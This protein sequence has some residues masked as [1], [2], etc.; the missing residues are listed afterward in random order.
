MH[1]S[2]GFSIYDLKE[3]N[4][5]IDDRLSSIMPEVTGLKSQ[6]YLEL[7]AQMEGIN[8][9]IEAEMERLIPALSNLGTTS[10][11]FNSDIK[12]GKYIYHKFRANNSFGAKVISEVIFVLGDDNDIE[13]VIDLDSI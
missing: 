2:S 6:S 7:I 5:L 4:I 1:P 11:R 8:Y 12:A 13:N 9:R 10:K 3:T